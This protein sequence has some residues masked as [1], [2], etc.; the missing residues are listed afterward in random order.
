[1]KLKWLCMQKKMDIIV[2]FALRSTTQEIA[3]LWQSMFQRLHI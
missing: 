1:M 2:G 3:I